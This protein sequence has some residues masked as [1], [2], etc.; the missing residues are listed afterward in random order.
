MKESLIGVDIGGTKCAITYGCREG[1]TLRLLDEE[2]FSTTTVDA[3]IKAIIACVEKMISKH[4]LTAE[5]IAAIG[6]SCGGPLDSHNGVIMSPPNLPGW[7]GVPI[8]SVMSEHFGVRTG[9]QNDANACALAEWKCGAG[10]GSRNMVFM[11]FGTGLGSGLI[12]DGK[13]YSGTNDN[14]GELG[15][16]RLSEFGP[17]GYGKAGSFEGFCSGGGLSQIARMLIQEK[18]QMG[19]VVSWC[20][21]EALEQLTAQKIAE[22]AFSGDPLALQIFDISAQKL[23]EGLSIVIDLLNPELIVIGGIYTRCRNLMEPVMLEAIAKETLPNAGRVCR[24][25]PSELAEQIGAYSALSVAADLLTK[26]N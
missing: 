17:V 25:L 8:V 12:L 4:Q 9:L 11:T 3:T 22:A 19:T 21:P 24:I 23:G 20:K 5:A 14:A 13:L 15:R 10:R 6:I 7:D 18:T 2:R 16:I 1:E 26:N